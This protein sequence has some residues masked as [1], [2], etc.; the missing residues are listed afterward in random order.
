MNKKVLSALLFGALMAGTGTFTSCIDTD[1]PAGIEELRGAK[2]ELIRAKVAVEQANAAY[3]L[4]AAEYQKALAAHEQAN[5][6]Y[7]LAEAK[8]MEAKAEYEEAVTA[9]RKALAEKNMAQYKLDMELAVAKHQQAMASWQTAIATAQ[10]TY[11]VTLKQIAI[12][13]ALCVTDLDNITLSNFE[14]KV[15]DLYADIYGGKKSNGLSVSAENSLVGI[16]RA[17]E[18]D[19]YYATLN[20]AAG[21]DSSTN[22]QMSNNAPQSVWIPTLERE[23]AAKKALLEE[24]KTLLAEAE[25]FLDVETSA[26]AWV[27]RIDELKDSIAVLEAEKSELSIKLAEAKKNDEYLAAYT[28]KHGV[29]NEQNVTIK[30]GTAQLLT[31]AKNAY[32]LKAQGGLDAQGN[33]VEAEELTLAEQEVK[34][35]GTL[36]EIINTVL[37]NTSLDGW[38]SDAEGN[39]T[40]AYEEQTY[41]MPLYGSEY[42]ENDNP[43]TTKAKVEG[44][45]E[46]L[47][48]AVIDENDLAMAQIQLD[49]QK[50]T[51]NEKDSLYKVA[52]V[53]WGYAKEAYIYAETDGAQGK[54]E[55]VPTAEYQKAVDAYNTKVASF[56]NALT[57]YETAYAGVVAE[58]KAEGKAEYLLDAKYD[59]FM[60]LAESK[61]K[62]SPYIDTDAN[63]W[64]KAEAKVTLADGDKDV[65]MTGIKSLF[66]A[67]STVTDATKKA[68]YAAGLA[69]L[70]KLLELYMAEYEYTNR[71][72]IADKETAGATSALKAAAAKDKALYSAKAEI[73]K[74][75]TAMLAAYN[76]LFNTTATA[77]CATEAFE[78]VAQNPYL[79][80]LTADAETAKAAM[81][82][83]VEVVTVT[84]PETTYSEAAYPAK[85]TV[86]DSDKVAITAEEFAAAT[87]TE[88]VSNIEDA[89][90]DVCDDTF[91]KNEALL[92]APAWDEISATATDTN[93]ASVLKY[94]QKQLATYEEQI[95]AAD[96][97]EALKEEIVAIQT[98]LDAEIAANEAKFDELAAA[99]LAADKADKDADA[100]LEE[101]GKEVTAI[102]VE[103]A[104]AGYTIAGLESIETA[105][106]TA[107]EKFFDKQGQIFTAN[108]EDFE[109]YWNDSVISMF[110]QDVEDAE[111]AVALAE[112]NLKMA[113][114]GK[115][116]TVANAQYKLDNAN[117]N[118]ENALAKYEKALADLEKY[119]EIMAAE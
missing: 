57:A 50:K 104:M 44:W 92:V 36:A 84:T 78:N 71:T 85:Y 79:Q 37:D 41:K 32:D 94:A 52:L 19:L 61:L 103:I 22:S 25:S 15:T 43:L 64:S 96:D 82:K 40:F 13:K 20:K 12:A 49:N 39:Y 5:A 73:I 90:K 27:A 88:V 53:K 18:K 34:V 102:E 81:T 29:K 99:I 31:D 48:D 108:Y 107:I 95:A 100:A 35:N 110:A 67:P 97:L 30:K 74:T 111:K 11:E 98:A 42:D 7:R 91:G 55:T 65:A 93:A 10:H 89:L 113:Q 51:V 54:L 21:L 16:V 9:E 69:D 80:T 63:I 33:L 86:T 114:D 24:Q 17:A 1:E 8:Y 2:A 58:G 14:N 59:K 28:T 117:Q 112:R 72:T 115:Y 66:A 77:T 76:A 62:A 101:A 109:E 23:V 47:E 6:E 60:E 70:E 26:S 75:Q 4:A 116:D 83:R 3:T 118:L 105:I 87:E 45:I 38:S 56:L 46:T 119:L 68:E 106:E